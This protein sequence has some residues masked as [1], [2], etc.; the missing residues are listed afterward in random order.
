MTPNTEEEQDD[1]LDEILGNL[2]RSYSSY[3]EQLAFVPT[4]VAQAKAAI[5]AHEQQ[6]VRAARIDELKKTVIAQGSYAEDRS[7]GWGAFH[8]VPV[9][10]VEERITELSP[11]PLK[12]TQSS[13][14]VT[15]RR[16]PTSMKMI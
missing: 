15:L 7:Y 6:A 11:E 3:D 10:E 8:H 13:H 16:K 5:T 12:A 2:I 14:R 9:K 1:W 4:T